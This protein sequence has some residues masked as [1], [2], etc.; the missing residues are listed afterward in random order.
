MAGDR[1]MQNDFSVFF[2]ERCVGRIRLAAGRIG[3]DASWAWVISK[4]AIILLRM[5]WHSAAN[6]ALLFGLEAAEAR[7]W[8]EPRRVILPGWG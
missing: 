2:D 7:F 3:I 1:L 4:R 5:D 8:A 6:R